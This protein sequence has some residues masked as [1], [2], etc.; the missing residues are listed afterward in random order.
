MIFFMR[1]M[2]TAAAG[3]VYTTSVRATLLLLLTLLPRPQQETRTGETVRYKEFGEIIEEIAKTVQACP[4]DKALVVWLIDNSSLLKA[5]KHGEMFSDSLARFF[6]KG[7][8]WHAVVAFG[9]VPRLVLKAT[10]DPA[11]AAAAI[12]GLADEKPDD[13]IKNCLMNVREAARYASGFTGKSNKFLIL[14]TQQNGDNEDDVEATL[15]MLRGTGVT[16]LPISNE[17][18]YSDP[19]WAS[20]FN[21]TTFFFDLAPYRKLKFELRGPES[22]FIEFPYGWPLCVID[23]A[24]TAPS[25]FGYWALN[26]LATYSGGKY[27]LYHAE[28]TTQ[29]F[30]QRYACPVCSGNHRA[31]GSIF[32]D[33]K[34]KVDAPDVG[35]RR[36]Y[37]VRC[38]KEKLYHANLQTWERLHK[39]S[40]L[41]GPP[42]L[43]SSG[44]GLAEA[45]GRGAAAPLAGSD[46]R[47][48]AAAAHR[49]AREVDDAAGEL[50]AAE[51]ALK[52]DSDRRALA[53]TDALIVHLRVLSCAYDELAGFCEEMA[54]KRDPDVIGY[55]YRSVFLCHGGEPLKH[56]GW[57]GE[58]T[59]INDALDL[60]DRMI[61]GHLGTP[62]ETLMR[63]ASLPV[64]TPVRQVR[65]GPTRRDRP[66]KPTSD[67]SSTATPSRPSRPNQGDQGGSGGT[68][69]GN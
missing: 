59:K 21:G 14:F 69:T 22:A 35:S 24:Y 58:R 19:F 52:K 47:S 23:P 64:F 42:P 61:E 8:A 20:A 54:R 13:A 49:S 11:Q 30:C 50:L 17:A 5:T 57:L 36:D 12:Q 2:I 27:Y 67:S 25:G 32:D 6:K 10:D 1:Q 37:L 44:G 51:E 62:W 46:W 48:I 39:K 55:S 29:S 68:S 56:F 41:R 40:I 65:E 60:A 66:P 31:C 34:L 43:K 45:K 38:S 9:E 28:R 15:A 26:R 53:T 63:R 33:T 7:K 16:F 18:V 3:M 4:E